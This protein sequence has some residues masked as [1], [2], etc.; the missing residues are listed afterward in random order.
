MQSKLSFLCRAVL[1]SVFLYSIG[2]VVAVAET[3]YDLSTAALNGSSGENTFYAGNATLSIGSGNSSLT[4]QGTTQGFSYV[5]GYFNPTSLVNVGDK[6]VFSFTATFSNYATSAGAGPQAL[7]LG[8]FNSGGS[9]LT[10]N[11]SSTD[12]S[13][14]NAYT[15]YRAD[16]NPN[17]SPGSVLSQIRERNSTSTN[18]FSS[19]ATAVLTSTPT[20]T[21]LLGLT[22]APFS[23]MFSIEK[24]TTGI[25]LTSTVNGTQSV[26]A[27]DDASAF[28]NFDTFSF[29]MYGETPASPPSLSFSDLQV[30]YLAVPEPAAMTMLASGFG[31]L[32]LITIRKRIHESA[33]TS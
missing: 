10:A 22:S 15:G 20:T 26:T 23:G 5:V 9:L 30:S 11:S 7:R 1:A 4:L 33:V 13:I 31:L 28:T 29:F 14:F 2:T 19:G 6:A 17:S 27:L 16:Y 3:L 25:L 12:T 21:P 8:L 32:M 24:T 18:L